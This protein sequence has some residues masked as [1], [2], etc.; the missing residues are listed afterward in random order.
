MAEGIKV[1]VRSNI[2]AVLRDMKAF[3]SG[4]VDQALPKALNR[5]IDMARTQTARN[6]VADGYNVKNSEI[7]RG[8]KLVMASRGMR[9]VRMRVPRDAKSLMEFDPRES[10]AG[11]SV[12]VHKGRKVIKHAFIGQL[13][14]GRVGVYIEDQAAGKLVMRKSKVHKKGSVGGWK[15]YPVRKLYGPSIGGAF[16]NEQLQSMLQTF[17]DSKLEERLRY[18]I[19]RARR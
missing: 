11:V 6:M 17:V 15:A 18:E 19:G 7:K 3:E 12:K 9:G 1:D 14:N 8:I 2:D 5:V 16:V 13:R 4:V 10:K